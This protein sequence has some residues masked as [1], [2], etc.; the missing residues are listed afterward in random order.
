[1]APQL[2][3]NLIAQDAETFV[4]LGLVVGFEGGD[5]FDDGGGGCYGGGGG[6][7]RCG[8][9][10]VRGREADVA[11]FVV[12]HGDVEGAGYGS[13]RGSGGKGVEG[14]PAAVPVIFI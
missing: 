2:L 5:L 11:V 6:G 9:E 3:E 14:A 4:D 1:M 7:K 13:G 10:V 12:V 8:G